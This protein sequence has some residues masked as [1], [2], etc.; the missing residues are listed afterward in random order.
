MIRPNM[1][2][3]KTF[4]IFSAVLFA[5]ILVVG[6]IAFVFSM[7]QIIRTNKGDELTHLLELE[8]HK[9]EA[10]VNSD[11]AIVLKMAT[12]P[13]VRQYFLDPDDP[14][15][16]ETAFKDFEG[17]RNIFTS[18]SIFWVVD[19]NLKFY[20]DFEHAYTVDPDDPELY[21]YN[22]TMYETERYNFN[23]DYDPFLK[24][25]NIWINAPVFDDFGNPL[26]ILGIGV[27]LSDFISAIYQKYAGDAELYFF[28]V[29]GEV[30]GAKDVDIVAAKI[31]IDEILGDGIM[32]IARGLGSDQIIT[33]DIPGG[34]AAVG[35]VPALEWYS[36]AFMQDRI[37]DYFTAMTVLFLVVLALFLL[38]VVIFNIFVAGF[39]KSLRR[40]SESLASLA[41]K[42]EQ[43]LMADNEI[44][45]RLNRM[46]NEFFQNMNHDFKTP[47]NVIST[48]LY[49]VKD[50]LD[51][52]INKD[53]MGG[54]IDNAEQEVMRMARMVDSA[55]VY[56]SLSDN[57]QI[58]EPIDIA[59]LLRKGAETYRSLLERHNNSLDLDIPQSFPPIFG[60]ADMLL[61][62]LSNLLSNTNRYTRNGRISIQAVE[63][64]GLITVKIQDDGSGIEPELLPRIFERGV[65]DGGTGLGL[66]ICKT[67]IETHGGSITAESEYG[68]GT[69]ITFT[70]PVYVNPELEVKNYG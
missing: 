22:M 4:I 6:S 63:A 35:T 36:A 19:S 14:M 61:H 21:W 56:S 46:K 62:V 57:R 64:E 55:M 60:S 18:A 2:V 23:I 33:L 9:L 48:S 66:S 7:Q 38:I 26:G 43:E 65:S 5:I 15:A 34:T 54:V 39:V 53:I 16:A 59:P 67:A 40:A 28:N 47:L 24:V 52:E 10:E 58:M 20:M 32:D 29:F 13:V 41:Q 69:Q 44:L 68:W 45:D 17:Y 8:R 37:E 1:P 3:M 31:Q 30:T 11:I 50:M 49:N 42:R 27:N 25:T 70:L 51:F 12:S